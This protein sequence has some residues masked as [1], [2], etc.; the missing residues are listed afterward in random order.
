MQS[1]QASTEGLKIIRQA[2]QAT[3]FNLDDERWHIEAS[4][5][6]KSWNHKEIKDSTWKRFYKGELI[7]AENFKAFCEL[8][9]LDWEKIYKQGLRNPQESKCIETIKQ[10]GTF[11]R[12]KGPQGMGKT[13][14]LNRVLDQ[15]DHSIYRVAM[16]NFRR[17][18]DS[19]AYET[20]HNFYQA[21]C[22]SLSYELKIPDAIDQYWIE[23]P[24]ARL[25]ANESMSRYI[26]KHV[27]ENLDTGTNLVLILQDVDRMFE[28]SHLRRDVCDMLRGWVSEAQREDIWQ[29]LRLVVIHSTDVYA[30]FDILVSPLFGVGEV[31]EL[32]E[33]TPGQVKDLIRQYQ[34]SDEI[35]SALIQLVGGH[36]FLVDHA[37]KSLANSS[38]T[39]DD[40]LRTAATAEGIYRNHLLSIWYTIKQQQNLKEAVL[41]VISSAEPIRIFDQ[42]TLFKLY[43]LGLVKTDQDRASI[44]NELYRRYFAACLIEEGS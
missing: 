44:R 4:E 15:I 11:L 9:N 31:V 27:L 24:K 14:M 16:I 34:L 36:P 41:K 22:A 12:I 26:E 25:T 19:E 35:H 39:F 37:L 33:F 32:D 29:R 13:Q 1:L 7:K 28:Y 42:T 43:S 38:K 17:A 8:L 3:G 30:A 5:I 21:I 6:L 10:P 23:K 18:L 40:F 20:L 2:R